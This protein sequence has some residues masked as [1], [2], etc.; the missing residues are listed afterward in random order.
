MVVLKN[1]SYIQMQM[2][3]KFKKKKLKMR[4]MFCLYGALINVRSSNTAH[5]EFV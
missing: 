4:F 1:D 3:E 2:N 5:N